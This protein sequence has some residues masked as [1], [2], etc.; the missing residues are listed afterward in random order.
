MWSDGDVVLLRGVFRGILTWAV[1]HRLVFRNDAVVALYVAPGTPAKITGRDGDGR[2]LDR[3]GN[4]ELGDHVWQWH[5]VLR[6]SRLNEAHSVDLYWDGSERAF[7][8]WYVNLQEPLVEDALGFHTRDNVLDL[9]V[10]PDGSWQWKDED[11][12][13]EAVERGYF[14][15]AEASAIRAEGERVLADPP[16]PTDWEDWRP[17]PAWPIP[18]LPDGWD[19]P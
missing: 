2:Y 19:R 1:P 4:G 9:W 13:V 10:E 14:T 15:P 5:G 17:D 7:L 12:L 18:E 11:E 8:G 3:W 16:W 6:L